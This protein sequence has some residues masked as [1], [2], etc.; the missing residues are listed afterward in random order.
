MFG[1]SFDDFRVGFLGLVEDETE[2]DC[3]GILFEWQKSD[4]IDNVA[5]NDILVLCGLVMFLCVLDDLLC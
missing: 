4:G 2:D 5:E 1:E 3:V